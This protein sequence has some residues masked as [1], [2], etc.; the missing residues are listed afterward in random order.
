MSKQAREQAKIDM[1]QKFIDAIADSEVKLTD[2]E[3]NECL[4]RAK[5]SAKS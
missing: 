4:S 5:I 1:E 2:A 3:I